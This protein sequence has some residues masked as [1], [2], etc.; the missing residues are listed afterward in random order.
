MTMLRRWLKS[1]G[2]FWY[3]F[4]IGDDWTVAATA[5]AALLVTWLLHTVA[6]ATWWLPPLA[7]VVAV[8]VSLHRTG[9][10]ATGSGR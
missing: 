1:F 5:A 9:R 6:V 2:R 8:G 3:G 7:A 4:I 10:A